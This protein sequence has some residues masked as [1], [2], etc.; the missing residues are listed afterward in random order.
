VVCVNHFTFDTDAEITL[1]KKNA[2]MSKMRGFHI[3]Q[4]A[5]EQKNWPR[6]VSIVD[7]VNP[8]SVCHR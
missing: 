2:V 6:S 4:K 5:P 1:L 7:A 8:N 3:G